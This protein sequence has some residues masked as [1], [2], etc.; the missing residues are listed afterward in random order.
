MKITYLNH[1]GMLLQTDK[2]A[3][4]IDYYSNGM[5]KSTQQ[6]LQNALSAH[7]RVYVLI[8]HAH[9]DHYDQDALNFKGKDGVEPTFIFSFDAEKKKHHKGTHFLQSGQTYTDD[10]LHCKA[11]GSTDEG[12]SFYLEFGG[13]QLFH[14]GDLNNWHWK[15][16]VDAQEADGYQTAY[17]KE[18][19]II[20]ADISHLDALMFPV[21]PRLAVDYDIG[22]IQ[23]ASAIRVDTLLPMHFGNDFAAIQAVAG[24]LA[25]LV[26]KYVVWQSMGESVEV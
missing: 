5:N 14:A 25:P 4:V 9:G 26:G 7:T 2:A 10:L 1:S 13:K 6:L 11:Y 19:D 18:L 23:F 21:D 12:I 3:I 22:A 17:L 8:S 16:E 20:K 24:Q 15:A